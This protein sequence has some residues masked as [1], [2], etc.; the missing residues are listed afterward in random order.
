[1][2]NKKFGI[3]FGEFQDI[4]KD[5]RRLEADIK[6]TTEKALIET[7]DYIAQQADKYTDNKYLPAKGKY[8][9]LPSKTK[10]A[11]IKD[12]KIYWEGTKATVYTGFS[13]EFGF[14]P[15]FLMYGTPTMK[16]AKGLKNAIVGNKTKKAVAE[17]QKKTFYKAC[18]EAERNG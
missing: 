5:M 10:R 6:E 13:F 15:Q 16:P 8:R 17:I 2:S 11:I 3:E 1:M 18:R 7:Q 12:K 4:L 14:T 9:V